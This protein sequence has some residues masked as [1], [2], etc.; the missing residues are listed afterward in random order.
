MRI[1]KLSKSDHTLEAIVYSALGEEGK[2]VQ[3]DF[4]DKSDCSILF[5]AMEAFNKKWADGERD[6]FNLNHNDKEILKGCEL[7]ESYITDK[8]E[9]VDTDAGNMIVPECSWRIKLKLSEEAFKLVEGK[10][11]GISMQGSGIGRE[12]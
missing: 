10:A 9:L 5:D 8:E 4:I 7:E 1:I 11:T 12:V 2:D 6:L 3:G